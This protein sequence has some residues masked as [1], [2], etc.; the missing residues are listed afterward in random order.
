MT[1]ISALVLIVMMLSVCGRNS[2]GC[3]NNEDHMAKG[4]TEDLVHG[5]DLQLFCLLLHVLHTFL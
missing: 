2:S 5:G 4:Q 3:S 1:K